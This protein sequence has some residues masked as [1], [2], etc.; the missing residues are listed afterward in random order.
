LHSSFT[1]EEFIRGDFEDVDSHAFIYQ[2]G[3]EKWSWMVM[4][5]QVV[6]IALALMKWNA[7]PV[8]SNAVVNLLVIAIMVGGIL[9]AEKNGLLRT[10][11]IL[12]V[13]SFLI[14]SNL[15]VG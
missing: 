11:M 10:Y 2:L 7:I 1:I 12:S 9:L 14:E 15:N 8:Y 3:E 4:I 6:F 5:S 13:A